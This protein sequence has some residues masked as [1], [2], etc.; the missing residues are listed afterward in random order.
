MVHD[1]TVQDAIYEETEGR[2]GVSPISCIVSLA[3]QRGN[4][5][6]LT[7]GALDHAANSSS[8]CVLELLG[9]LVE[10]QMACWYFVMTPF[11]MLP[12]KA[13]GG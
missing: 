1:S 11:K 3:V 5:L 8:H 13:Q 4:S 2:R 12:Q 6:S 7:L 9:L 10:L